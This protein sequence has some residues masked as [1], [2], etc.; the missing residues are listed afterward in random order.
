MSNIQFIDI[1]GHVNF[2]DYGNEK[3]AVIKR[4]LDKGVS[5]ITVGTDVKTSMESLN[6]AK[7]TENIWATVGIHPADNRD[8]FGSSSINQIESLASDNKVVAIGECGLDYFH[9]KPED[10]SL[11]REIFTKQIELA[12]KVNKPLMLH[13]R[14]GKN[15]S[16]AYQDALDILKTAKVPANFHF[17]AGTLE[18]MKD[19]L[20]RGFS[21]SFTGVLTFTRDYDDLVKYAPIERIM[22]ETDCPFVSPAPYRGQRNEPSY[23]IEIV[24]AIAKIR[25]EDEKVV[26]GQL[27]DNAKKF[28]GIEVQ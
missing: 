13:V 28:F 11:Q 2:P 27:L 23:V 26:S 1:H 10:I 24:K 14:N 7:E 12:N 8:D 4:A 3:D 21:I 22:S 9:S 19:I 5:M 16:N 18:D 17:F 25:N 20:D 6:L 15:N